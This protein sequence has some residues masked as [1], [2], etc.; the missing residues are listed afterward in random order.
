M[1][2]KSA[3]SVMAA[4][5]TRTRKPG[6]MDRG[7]VCPALGSMGKYVVPHALDLKQQ[8]LRV[9]SSAVFLV[10][11]KLSGA[12]HRLPHAPVGHPYSETWCQPW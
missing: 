10:K 3:T 1:A 9:R 7:A 11:K 4:G 6:A 2:K 12:R 5:G 8:P